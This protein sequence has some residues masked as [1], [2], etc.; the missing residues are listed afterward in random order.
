MPQ[1]QAQRTINGPNSQV[2][3]VLA[4]FGGVHRFHPAVERSPITNG[5]PTGLG[6]RRTCHFYDGNALDEEI[7]EFNEPHRM[8]VSVGEGPIPVNN[9][10][11]TFTL[12]AVTPEQ[13]TVTVAMDYAPKFGPVGAVMNALLLR[14]KIAG[15]LESVLSG[16]AA[17]VE[18]GVLIG[19][20][21]EKLPAPRVAI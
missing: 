13:T 18:T 4:D 19:K 2:W 15:L 11:A 16:L 21:G 17:H 5:T 1:V 12:E 20:N 7:V 10:L 3:A 6:S 9:L 14:R 8:V